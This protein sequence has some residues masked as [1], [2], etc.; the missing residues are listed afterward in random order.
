MRSVVQHSKIGRWLAAE[1]Q[2]RRSPARSH[3]PWNR[4]DRGGNA[5]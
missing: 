2:Q 1:G 5:V 4:R 3:R